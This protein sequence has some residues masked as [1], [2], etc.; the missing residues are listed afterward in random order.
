MSGPSSGSPTGFN[1][2]GANGGAA[3][4]GLTL[5]ETDPYAMSGDGGRGGNSAPN[6]SSNAPSASA[7]GYG[8][9]GGGGGSAGPANRR[10]GTSGA[11]GNGFIVVQFI[12]G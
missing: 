9:G 12:E 11:G 8:A 4:N 7:G 3:H 5:S 10:G 1:S 6:G 2:Q